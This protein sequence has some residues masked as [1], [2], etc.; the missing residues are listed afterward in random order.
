MEF[1]K[2]N[3]WKLE[4]A[5]PEHMPCGFEVS[6]PTLIEMGRKLDIEVP[7]DYPIFKEIYAKRNLKLQRIPKDILHKVPTPLLHTLEG[8]GMTVPHCYP[9]DLFERLWVVDRLERLGISR[10]F[11]SEIKACLDCVYR[12]AMVC[13]LPWLETKFYLEQYGGE[14][15]V[16]I[17]K[18]LYRM[19]NI[20]NNK[21]LELAKLDYKNCQGLHL[22]EWDSIQK[23]DT[24]TRIQKFAAYLKTK[25]NVLIRLMLSIAWCLDGTQNATLNISDKQKDLLLRTI[26]QQQVSLNRQGQKSELNGL[27]PKY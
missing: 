27:K 21:Y 19:P 16:W 18:I 2:E 12:R 22:R 8:L 15:D 6:F 4:F 9:M 14:D 26:W 5:N 20:S 25:T 10:Y 7:D 17:A 24:I 23:Y 13:H 11:Q 1:L 3:I